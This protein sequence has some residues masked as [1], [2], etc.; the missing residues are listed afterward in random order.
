MYGKSKRFS[1]SLHRNNDPKSRQVI[2]NYLAR[3]GLIVKDNPDKFGVDLIS[4]DGLLK[5]EVEHRLPWVDEEFP[6]NE[7][8]FFKDGDVQYII[9]S[10]GYDRLGIVTGEEIKPFIVDDN[11][12][13]NPNRFVKNDEYFFKIPK[14]IFKWVKL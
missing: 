5:I 14:G 12:V 8:K 7:S 13:V 4:D 3:Y 10:R 2:K 11:L 9:L 1:S 6:Y